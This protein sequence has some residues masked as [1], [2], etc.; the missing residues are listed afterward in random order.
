ME[1]GSDSLPDFSPDWAVFLDVDGTLLDITERPFGTRVDPD[2]R[3]LLR[4]LF[5]V[6]GGAMA[7]ISGRSVAD[8]DRLFAS[9][10]FCVAGQHGAERRD[11]AGRLH[12]HQLSDGRLRKAGDQLRRMVAEHPGLVLEEKSMSLALHYRLAPDLG[13]QVRD[14]MRG[15][16]EDL[17]DE[18]EMQAGKMVFEVK[19]GGRDKGT[20]IGEFMEE[21][22]FRG[23]LPVFIGDDLTDEFGFEIVNRIGGYSVKVGE[24]MSAARLRLADARAVRAWLGKIVGQWRFPGGASS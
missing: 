21:K 8:V 11:A 1:T 17:G 15:L 3:R 9:S 12:R 23:R 16:V 6:T 4:A 14:V 13:A 19:S 22:P 20:A 10:R 7:L 2:L 18:F 24:G 5:E